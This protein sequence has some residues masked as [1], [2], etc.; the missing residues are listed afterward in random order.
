MFIVH[1]KDGRSI[2]EDEIIKDI[3]YDWK[4]IK[5]VSNNLKDITAV[6]IKHNKGIYYTMSIKGENVELLQLKA[7]V[8]DMIKG[9][10]ELR[11]RILGFIIKDDKG[12]PQYAVKMRISE[13]TGGVVLGLEK[14]TDKG[15]VD[16]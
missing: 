8:I 14:R 11:E 7:N 1:L 3:V 2:K 6:Q 10:D 5:E 13:K 15:W 12:N 16:L 9:T 4:K